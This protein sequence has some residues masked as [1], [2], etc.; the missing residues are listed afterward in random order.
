MI[1][2]GVTLLFEQPANSHLMRTVRFVL[3]PVD[4]DRGLCDPLAPLERLQ[5]LHD[6]FAR[7]HD[8]PRQFA[9]VGADD[10]DLIQADDRRARVDRVH[11]V[12]ERSGEAMDVFPVERRHER[13]VQALDDFMRQE[14]ALVLDLLDLVRL[15]PE[16]L[17]RREH[18]FED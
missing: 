5:R 17:F 9:R 10:L 12:V 3:Q 14:V 13:T 18:L 16:R 7:G 15:V 2:N 1:L 11:H 4:L 8:D 6:L